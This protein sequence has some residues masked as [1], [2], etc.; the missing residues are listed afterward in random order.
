[1]RII[2]GRFKG[3]KLANPPE[4]VRPTAVRLRESFFSVVAD[5]TEGA[6]WL[7]A[8]AGSGAVGIEALSRGAGLVLFNDRDPEAIRLIEA[9]LGR[10]RI[11]GGAEVVRI[12]LFT[13]LR[14]W[15]RPPMDFV[16]LDPPYDFGRYD[17][18]MEKFDRSAAVRQGTW[19]AV[20]T[21]KFTELKPPLGWK[22]IRVLSASDS[23]LHLYEVGKRENR[24]GA[25]HRKS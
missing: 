16:Y 23:R 12:E 10:C 18:L 4:G 6:S 25:A 5:K 15:K 7:D 17:K 9:N 2:A 13:L 24:A 21:S 22:E 20:E 11:A 3:R 14:T 1:M 8:F 19:A